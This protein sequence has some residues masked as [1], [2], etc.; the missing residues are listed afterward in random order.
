[1]DDMK[2]IWQM[3]MNRS[4]RRSIRTEQCILIDRQLDWSW[5]WIDEF[6]QQWA[7]SCIK[8]LCHIDKP[9][10]LRR[11]SIDFDDSIISDME[12]SSVVNA[13]YS[14]VPVYIQ[15]SINSQHEVSLSC[16]SMFPF[17]TVLSDWFFGMDCSEHRASP[18]CECT[19]FWC[20]ASCYPDINSSY[21]DTP[22]DVY[23]VLHLVY[24][25]MFTKMSIHNPEHPSTVNTQDLDVSAHDHR[26]INLPSCI[27][28]TCHILHL[29]HLLS[30]IRARKEEWP[31]KLRVEWAADRRRKGESRNACCKSTLRLTCL[32][33]EHHR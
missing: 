22:S 10:I 11:L 17:P 31:S 29:K 5:R 30:K 7:I 6:K 9:N 24:K 1:M 4:G 33:A 28:S 8:G 12:W 15:Q 16:E 14:H 19:I 3:P 25:F 2:L 13:Q 26:D 18:S 27:A 32:R 20:I 23:D 21:K